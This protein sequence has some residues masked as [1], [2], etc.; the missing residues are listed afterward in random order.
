MHASLDS[1]SL[2]KLYIR[3]QKRLNEEKFQY[4]GS[5]TSFFS[6]FF[7]K[8]EDVFEPAQDSRT[9]RR[10]DCGYIP[11]EHKGIGRE[12]TNLHSYP[13]PEY[14]FFLPSAD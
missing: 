14:N 5:K 2:T 1:V 10:Q 12:S 6:F 9:I 4:K 7:S 11:G 8:Q 13:L 3:C